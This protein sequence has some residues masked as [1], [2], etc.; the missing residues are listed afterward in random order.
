MNRSRSDTSAEP[1]GSVQARNDQ[2][3]AAKAHKWPRQLGRFQRG[4]GP[5]IELEQ[6]EVQVEITNRM[7]DLLEEGFDVVRVVRQQTAAEAL[8]L[9]RPALPP[10]VLCLDEP[11]LPFSQML[12]IAQRPLG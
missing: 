4:A 3:A 11:S 1:A 8:G 2:T 5:G 6:V 12:P 7:V 10:G 9:G